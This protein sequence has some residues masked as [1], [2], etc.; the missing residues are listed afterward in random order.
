[1]IEKPQMEKLL[2]RRWGAFPICIP[3]YKRW[4]RKENK[5][6]TG[7]I[8]KC[9]AELQANTHVFVRAEQEQAYRASFPTVN[10]V[11]LP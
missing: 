9:D 8:E 4:D 5:T 3:S 2:A 1:M 6:I 11:A 7:I 10:I